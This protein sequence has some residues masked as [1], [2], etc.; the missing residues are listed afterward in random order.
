MTDTLTKKV[1][2]D[3]AAHSYALLTQ[4]F[5]NF[6]G[7]MRI[8]YR[9]DYLQ[10]SQ[11]FKR[12]QN[13]R[14]RYTGSSIMTPPDNGW[15]TLR[16]AFDDRA[17]IDPHHK[18]NDVD[19][20]H[21]ILGHYASLKQGLRRETSGKALWLRT[22]DNDNAWLRSS[23][24]ETINGHAVYG[25]VLSTSHDQD[26]A[27][28]DSY[29][30]PLFL[31]RFRREEIPN[32]YLLA[33]D[34]L[35][36]IEMIS[37]EVMDKALSAIRKFFKDTEILGPNMHTKIDEQVRRILEDRRHFALVSKKGEKSSQ[38]PEDVLENVRSYVRGG[39]A[40]QSRTE[41]GYSKPRV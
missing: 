18:V 21:L 33:V 12:P 7:N 37:P 1:L 36:G 10:A 28:S 5:L 8:S 38:L 19:W 24:T 26:A 25:Y 17:W 13:G 2:D 32:F 11:L 40:G 20:S 39:G 9:D 3:Y 16:S 4:K 41:R 22:D 27:S 34:E 29:R 14:N 23:G 15:D 31:L 35:S 30:V 6:L